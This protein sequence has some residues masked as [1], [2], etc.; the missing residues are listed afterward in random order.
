MS[1]IN[2]DTLT[3]FEQKRRQLEQQILDLQNSIY[4][5]R[6]WNAEYDALKEEILAL[7]EDSTRE[8]ILRIGRELGG[9]EVTENE[10]RTLLGEEPSTTAST[11]HSR[12]ISRSRPQVMD[13]IHRRIDYVSDNIRIL[14]K[15]L[16]T[17]Q[18]NLNALHVKRPDI[19]TDE[20][21]LPIM[22]IV[23]EL[24][25]DGN[26]ISGSTTTPGASTDE[27]LGVLKK[28][29]LEVP[30]GKTSAD[31]KANSESALKSEN[32]SSEI[33]R[34]DS[35][36]TNMQLSTTGVENSHIYDDESAPSVSKAGSQTSMGSEVTET[37]DDEFDP[38]MMEVIQET[39][40]DAA[41]RKE[42]LQY[43]LE[44]VGAIVAEMD[45]FESGS[46]I[47]IE[48]EDYTLSGDDDD[49]YEDEYGRTTRRVLDEDYVRQMQ[50]LE[51]KLKAKSLQNIGPDP[52]TL[53]SEVQM[54]IDRPPAV[55]KSAI[56][57][58]SDTAKQP[59]KKKKTVAFA[60]QLDIAPGPKSPPLAQPTPFS[61]PDRKQ[62]QK[63][64][65]PP[66]IQDTI[67]ERQTNN[68]EKPAIQPSPQPPK[69][70]SRFKTARKAEPASTKPSLSANPAPQS[71]N[72]ASSAGHSQ[73]P[74]YPPSLFPA[75]PSDPKP[76]SQPIIEP[77]STKSGGVMADTLV[78]RDVNRELPT[79]PPDTDGFDETLHRRQ[80][81]S[82]FYKLRNRKIQQ[83][84]GFMQED[85]EEREVIMVDDEQG[86]E[87]PKKVSRFK[88]A[89]VQQT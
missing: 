67:M 47:S 40:E 71:F 1:V 8:D 45:M 64:N 37:H 79:D 10:V 58:K 66:P 29:G 70:V 11:T 43:G 49:E 21:G 22:E 14:E 53:P 26:F 81:A 23:E 69:K 34:K 52:S 19:G 83:S 74:I 61:K 15:R 82:E 9:S 72:F 68:S 39:P 20:A 87:K 59:P 17:S 16:T 18:D 3:G 48:E 54:E 85:E 77:G 65:L 62:K 57:G 88:A 30:A 86:G 63:D 25:E 75:K 55:I 73:T 24:D 33:G 12:T 13:A 32:T 76:F 31:T 38:S 7:P 27:L 56:S 80:V 50:E 84:G 46:D 78:E 60:D 28:A 41:L 36:D 51:Q 2:G 89:R 35:G 44:E 4:K 5:W 6:I 42:M